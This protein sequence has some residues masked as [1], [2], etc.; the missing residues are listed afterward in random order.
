MQRLMQR[1]ISSETR[2]QEASLSRISPYRTRI[3]SSLIM[4]AVLTEYLSRAARQRMLNL[5]S[6]HT[7]LL[8]ILK[9]SLSA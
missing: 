1:L 6:V 7:P 5:L 3:S 4:K 8:I 2:M 9:S